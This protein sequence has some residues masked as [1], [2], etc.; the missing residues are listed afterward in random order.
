MA[1]VSKPVVAAL[2]TALGETKRTFH[3]LGKPLNPEK[4]Y[5]KSYFSHTMRF[6]AK[7]ALDESGLQ[8][9]IEDEQDDPGYSLGQAA[10][11]GIVLRLPGIV[12]RV[13]KS[14]ID[15]DLPP[16]GSESRAS[17]YEQRQYKILFPPFEGESAEVVDVET[18]DTE[19]DNAFHLVYAWDICPDLKKVYLK[20]VCPIDRTGKYEW[21]HIFS[22][23][24][25]TVAVSTVEPSSNPSSAPASLAAASAAAN[26]D[27][28]L[29]TKTASDQDEKKERVKSGVAKRA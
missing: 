9:R 23:E 25:L 28:D 20:L 4:P 6:I 16:A 7:R 26:T 24:E 8:A 3:S 18:T 1:S 5:D 15:E 13:L 14:P 27:L 10:N 29:S 21:Q 19:P 12:A 11:T 2:N 22:E 17:Y